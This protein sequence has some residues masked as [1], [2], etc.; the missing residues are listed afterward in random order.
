MFYVS[1][2]TFKVFKMTG[3]KKSQEVEQSLTHRSCGIKEKNVG[4]W[5]KKC[6][7]FEECYLWQWVR[8]IQRQSGVKFSLHIHEIQ[9]SESYSADLERGS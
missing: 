7:I 6:E 8:R 5:A 9:Q 2:V 1:A 3:E 4:I